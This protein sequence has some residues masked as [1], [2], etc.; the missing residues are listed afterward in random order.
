MPDLLT[1]FTN[2]WA[3]TFLGV[4]VGQLAIAVVVLLLALLLRRFFARVV[5]ARLS[6]WTRKTSTEIDDQILAALQQPLMFL[7]LIIG[8][9]IIV[10]WIPFGTDA[11]DILVKILQSFIAFTIFWTIYRMLDPISVFFDR[12][13]L[14]LAGPVAN[15]VKDYL[16]K[17]LKVFAAGSGIVAVLAQWGI[18]PWPYFA[19]IGVLSLPFAFAAKDAVSNVFGGIK[20]LIV[21]QA[22][23][24][25]DWIEAPSIGNGTVEEVTLST[26][27][28][29]KFSKAVQTVPNGVIAAE[30]IT[31]WSRMS[32]RRI[33]MDIGLTYDTTSEQF[34]VIL[35]TL[36]A[37]IA[38]DD[39]VDHSVTE[40]V[41][42][43]RFSESSIDINVYYFT[44]TT[45]WEEWRSIQEEHML[46]F[47]RIVE[48]AGANM[49]FPT[50]TVH[51]EGWPEGLQS[52]EG[53][54]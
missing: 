5:I 4:S 11:E 23:R 25:G 50:R 22:F 38:A 19:G 18:N 2:V 40:M 24:I 45:N 41:H 27:K 37:F 51:V 30:P 8:L 12:F 20:L 1:R 28:I 34:E 15:E 33:K 14:K 16:L 42:M 6:G 21:D 44:T 31:N 47:I 39:R 29:R 17:A 35:A 36:R 46:A 48:E 26:I 54:S 43:T 49:A 13:L 32:N 9:S 52:T 3:E 53:R 10:Q 7:F